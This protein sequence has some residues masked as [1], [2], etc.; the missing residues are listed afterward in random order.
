M[1]KSRAEDVEIDDN[2]AN[3]HLYGKSL[4][5]PILGKH[6]GLPGRCAVEQRI[7]VDITASYIPVF[8][9]L[10]IYEASN[11]EKPPT[12]P[13]IR[14]VARESYMEFYR[15]TKVDSHF[16]EETV[17]K[18]RRKST[19]KMTIAF[20]SNETNNGNTGKDVD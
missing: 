9:H 11:L 15:P 2:E 10:K 17:E 13:A 1:E 18:D 5:E 19:P 6:F 16:A 14:R 12:P 7:D 4:R 3:L 20:V 8:T